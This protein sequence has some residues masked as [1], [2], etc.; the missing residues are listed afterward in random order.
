MGSLN[1]NRDLLPKDIPGH[2]PTGIGTSS[3]PTRS[4]PCLQQVGFFK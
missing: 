2:P 1:Q 3:A 4:R